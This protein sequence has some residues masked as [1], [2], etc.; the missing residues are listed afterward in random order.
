MA[1]RDKNR[2]QNI[3]NRVALQA[4]Y[5]ALEFTGYLDVISYRKKQSQDGVQEW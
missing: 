5:G 2:Y 3:R 4:N 1:E